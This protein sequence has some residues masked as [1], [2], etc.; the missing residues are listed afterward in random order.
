VISTGFGAEGLPLRA[1][2][3]F[4]RAETAE[5]WVVAIEQLRVGALVHMAE[6]ARGALRDFTWPRIAAA[7]AA[8]YRQLTGS[9]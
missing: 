7:L 8:T 2:E 5:E 6:R 3:H 4:A 9:G 1:G